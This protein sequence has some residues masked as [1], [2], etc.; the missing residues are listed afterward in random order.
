MRKILTCLCCIAMTTSL[1]ACKGL[2]G[3][4]SGRQIALEGTDPVSFDFQGWKMQVSQPQVVWSEANAT[5]LLVIDATATNNTGKAAKFEDINYV[6]AYP[7]DSKDALGVVLQSEAVA[8]ENERLAKENASTGKPTEGGNNGE[9]IVSPNGQIYQNFEA[10]EEPT[11]N[12]SSIKLQYVWKLAGHYNDVRIEALGYA[13]SPDDTTLLMKELSETAE[14]T[15][16]VATQQAQNASNNNGTEVEIRGATVGKPA[17][18]KF[19][20]V[21]TVSVNLR[22]EAVNTNLVKVKFNTTRDSAHDQ[23]VKHAAYY[24][25]NEAAVEAAE[26]N[27]VEWFFFRPSPTSFQAFA[28]AT[29]GIVNVSSDVISWD[30]AQPALNTISVH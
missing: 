3:N 30:D 7:K 9:I 15:Q 13:P 2:T 28:K 18:W 23:A 29:T 1:V 12:G 4:G 24:N 16:Y 20:S 27:G 5:D 19:E 25:L 21:S 26:V 6:K 8:R 10:A 22:Q 11:E 17:G 14:Y